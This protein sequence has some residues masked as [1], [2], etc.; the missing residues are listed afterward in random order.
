MRFIISLILIVCLSALAEMQL[1]WGAVALVSFIVVLFSNLKPGMGFLAGFIAIAIYWA[2]V[3]VRAD[4]AN[5]HILSQRMAMLF[6]LPDSNLFI[7][8]SVIIGGLISGLGGWSGS[9]VRRML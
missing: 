1:A 7:V 4:A 2:W 9:L 5:D 8:V 3:A 6:H